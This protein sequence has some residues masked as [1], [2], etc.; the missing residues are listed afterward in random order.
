MRTGDISRKRRLQGDYRSH[1]YADYRTARMDPLALG[2]VRDMVVANAI[3]KFR[4]QYS[5]RKAKIAERERQA[6]IKNAKTLLLSRL[7]NKFHDS[8]SVLGTDQV[9][10]TSDGAVFQRCGIAPGGKQSFRQLRKGCRWN[11]DGLVVPLTQLEG[12]R[13]RCGVFVSENVAMKLC[14]MADYVW[15]ESL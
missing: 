7:W 4:R 5:E 2:V 14:L 1:F 11:F 15:G 3:A 6:Q 13:S 12:T 10:L 8:L 9:L